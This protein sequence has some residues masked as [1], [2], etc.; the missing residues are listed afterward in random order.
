V[1]QNNPAYTLS[2]GFGVL[3]LLFLTPACSTKK[4][5][6][7]TRFYHSVNTRY[8]IHYNADIAYKEALDAKER[9]REDNLSEIL[10]IFPQSSDSISPSGNFTTTVDKTTKAI[11]LHSIKAR[12]RR[13]PDRRG[14]A[15]Y[16]AWLQQKEFTPF[17]DQVW[18]LL[19]KAEFQDGDY[20]QT[21]TTF[22]Y[23]TKIYSSNPDIVAECRLW[24]ARAYTE[25]GW[26]YEAENILHKIEIAGGAPEKHKGLY[27]LVKANYLVYNNEYQA[28]IPH[29]ES[30][31][32]KEKN[33]LRKTRM[34]YLLGQL[35]AETNDK[36]K[37]DKAFASVK[38]MST[39]YKY[40]FNAR[41]RQIMLDD[42]QGK[43][44]A[45]SILSKMAKS[46]KNK[47]YLDQLY[48]AMGNV[49]LE[50]AD[51]TRAIDNYRKAITESI[52]GGYDKAVAQVRLG[53]VY[54]ARREFVLAQPC[55]SE[56]LSQLKRN[57]ADYPRVAL[58]SGVLDELVVHVKTVE[59]QDSLQYLAQLPETERLDIINNKIAELKEVEA[60]ALKEEEN[61]KRIEEKKNQISS[62]G[63]MEESL[64]E[65]A[66]PTP[67]TPAI[68]TQ[69]GASNSFYFYNE[70][71]VNQ[72]K[73]AFQ[74][75]WGTRKLEDDWRRK[76]KNSTGF[77]ESDITRESD[78]TP[79]EGQ[80]NL[81]ADNQKTESAG[82]VIED[83]YSVEYYLQQLPLTSEA[84]EASN[85]LIENALFNMGL[86]YKDKL[87]DMT[88]AI[89]AFGTD[90]RRFPYTPNLEEIYYQLL[91]IYMQA[92][93]SRM[94]SFYQ[95]KIL[96]EFSTGKYAESVS[97]PDFE[98]NFRHM[99]GLQDSLYDEAYKAY[100][101]GDVDVV[102]LNYQSMKK[103][104]PFTDLMPNFTLLNA[105]TYAQTRD[106][107]N[108]EASLTEMV[109][110]YPKS[111]VTPLATEILDRVKA[112]KILLSDG[113]PITDFDWSKAY[114]S[115]ESS[116]ES[117][118]K[119]SRYTDTLDSPYILLLMFK[120]NTI[121]RNE[122]LYE[123]ADYNF[124]NYVIQ[125]FDLSFESDPPYN[126]LQIKGFDSFN[127]IRSYLVR[128]YNG[129]GLMR[130]LD[131]SIVVLPI[132]TDNYI[133]VLPRLGLEKYMTYFSE[134]F[135]GQ[136][137][138]LI[139][140]WNGVV[141]DPVIK[142]VTRKT[143]EVDN[144]Q[145]T[146]IPTIE[147]PVIEPSVTAEKQEEEQGG[148]P[149]DDKQINADDLLTKDQ[150]QKAGQVN[151]VVENI[152]D[153]VNN[154]VDGIKN[155][156]NNYKNREK[157]TKEEKEALKIEEK[158]RKEQ[159]KNQKTILKARQDSIKKIEKAGTDA[160][161]KAEKA[162]EDSINNAKKQAE[163]R[164][165]LEEKQKEDAAQATL[166]A[167]ENLYKQKE[168]ERKG[169]ER[170][171][172]ERLRQQDKER[173]EKEKN[174][175]KERKE[176]EKQAEEKRKQQLKERGKR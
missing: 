141:Y 176:K 5:T 125:T 114:E 40:T 90:L 94:M 84:I 96:A 6:A 151:K 153:V 101:R 41:L 34:K 129:G 48:Y 3:L 167:R 105:L 159:E 97:Q 13:N 49:H 81:L 1:S 55:Y 25:M 69:Q 175:E 59:E 33:Q 91:L 93:D 132:S 75:Q 27:S 170:L 103:K 70:Q 99:A 149:A 61:M 45:L 122:L 121:D 10:Y 140:S 163:D 52:R 171:Q 15:D 58:R 98:W 127:S 17:M 169:R 131:T 46:P 65:Q 130:R 73:I 104:Y 172:K 19:A 154:P 142:P 165:R 4:N 57:H 107:Y 139:A 128:A 22:L 24:I 64:F 36:A 108:L 56:A 28:A 168:A 155:L 18:L 7:L 78:S 109:E 21:I 12:P 102:R 134:N 11:K 44:K 54:F 35:Y 123:V 74:K 133:N 111:E 120:P 143:D 147:T 68:P 112:G 42:S 43:A 31:V 106:A 47:E 158:Q 26:M 113:T 80:D 157:L 39:P 86:I 76:N 87:G 116:A 79:T 148:K 71:A 95:S 110:K 144:I 37:A 51:T 67:A 92:G 136:F 137:P 66:N 60:K 63:D 88:L 117:Q 166:K 8:N 2:I 50:K 124:S 146:E 9:G 100:R 118:N 53:D 119:V 126:V 72:G 85:I 138:Q 135:A 29:L 30:A 162:E 89:D 32:K 82:N 174:R 20:L 156:F 62:W 83:K 23:I 164:R 152:E 145:P 16:Q 77:L 150:L 115:G 14:D 160:I 161:A 173:K 38:G